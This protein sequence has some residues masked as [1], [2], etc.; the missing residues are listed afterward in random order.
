MPVFLISRNDAPLSLLDPACGE[1]AYVFVTDDAGLARR[2]RRLGFRTATG[3]L[4][5][6][7]LYRRLGIGAQ[8]QVLTH[9]TTTRDHDRVFKALL[10]AQ[11]DAAV[12]ALLEPQVKSPLR[13][14]DEVHFLPTRKLCSTTLQTELEKARTRRSLTAIRTLFRGAEK[15][16]LL[17]QDDPDP[18]GIASAL[19]L[20]ALL[21]RN[22]LTA[23]IGSFGEIKRP[24]NLAMTRLLDIHVE[25]LA[26]EDLPAFDRVA[27]LDVQPFHS[28]EIP[29]QVDL[30]IDHHPKRTNYS[31]KVRDIRPRYGATS[32]MMFEYLTAAGVTISQRLATALLYG[33]KTDTQ[34]LGRHT[35]PMDVAAFSELYLQGNPGLL[36]RI[37]RPQFPRRDLPALSQALQSANIIDDMVF[38]YLG[39]LTREDVIPY[40]ADFCLE[41][42][43]SEW[44]IVSGLSEG[45]LIVSVRNFGT[46]RSAGEVMKAGFECY[47]SAGGHKTMA[48]AVIPLERIPTECLDHDSWVRERFLLALYQGEAAGGADAAAAGAPAP[49]WGDE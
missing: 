4:H 1:A 47:G 40:I 22:R 48:K 20:R 11:P 29:T 18:D 14:G 41:G 7:A 33:I 34:L 13:W 6:P 27:L 44:S 28:P 16:L 19:A 37:D 43:G 2:A 45:K 31:A 36:R 24:E 5:D 10:E 25:R 3:R 35:T 26:R 15:I 39:P 49:H 30:V 9:L 32:T 42:E 46:G 8:D 17:V 21:G 12:T 38:A 23:V